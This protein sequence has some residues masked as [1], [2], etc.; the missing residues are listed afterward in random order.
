MGC[1]P[2]L[3]SRRPDFVRDGSTCCAAWP[4]LG[5]GAGASVM[6]YNAQTSYSRVNYASGCLSWPSVSFC[7][8]RQ[9]LYPR[10]V[11]TLRVFVVADYLPR[12]TGIVS[13]CPL[14]ALP[15]SNLPSF[16]P[17]P[18][19]PSWADGDPASASLCLS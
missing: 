19:E 15:L 6:F 2:P 1:S 16:P 17:L 18:L 4:S 5:G 9:S 14:G 11:L 12:K 3:E 10:G 7:C 8:A 13:V